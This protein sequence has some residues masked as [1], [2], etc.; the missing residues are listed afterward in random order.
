MHI[1]AVAAGKGG[2]G[3]S[4]LA[5][6]LSL[7]LKE[8]GAKV[9]VLDADIYG[10][11]LRTML[12]EEAPAQEDEGRISPAL[13]LGL[14][15]ISFSHF[16]DEAAIVRAPIVNGVIEQFIHNVDWGDLDFLVVDFPPGTGDIQLT[17]MQQMNF[18]GALLVTT[19]QKVSL[20]DV[21]KAAQMFTRME[22]PIIGIV[23]NMSYLI[24]SDYSPFGKG[25][26]KSLSERL[27]VPL[28]ACIPIDPE[29]SRSCD[30]GILLAKCESESFDIFLSIALVVKN[31]ESSL[32]PPQLSLTQEKT[33]CV[34]WNNDISR[35]W[36]AIAIQEMCPCIHCRDQKRLISEGVTLLS[37]ERVGRYAAR[38]RFSS[39]CSRGLYPLS[40]FNPSGVV[41]TKN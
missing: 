34:S 18:S 19:P 30:E 14:K 28:L 4:T 39:G 17:L 10:P 9:G 32:L 2:V 6:N 11:S 15:V 37:M 12:P 33:L 36:S 21:E 13:A 23:E 20:N 8:L 1:I 7:A 26:G 29:I 22:V 35:E 41:C 3:K 27:S 38:F 25:G 16:R 5:V 24:N 31:Y 40:L